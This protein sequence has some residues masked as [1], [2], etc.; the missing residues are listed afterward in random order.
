MKSFIKKRWYLILAV[1]GIVIYFIVRQ[2]ATN[3][4]TKKENKF[5]VTKQNLK[6]YLSLSGEIDADE[7]ATLRFQTSG[8]LAWVGVKEGDVVKK[9]Q[10]VASL[11]QRD[12]KNRLNKYLNTFVKNRLTFEQTHDDNWNRQYDLSESIR[13]SAQRT[14]EESQYDL[15]NSVLDVELQNL[16]L[17]YSNLWSPIDGIVTR[18]ESPFAGVNTTPTQAEIDIVNPK[19]IYF[20][21]TADQTEVINIKEKLK[22]KISMDSYSDK[23]IDAKIINIGLTPKTGETS[24]VYKVKIALDPNKIDISRFKLG[25]TGDASFL[26][27]EK[28][29]VLAVPSQFIKDNNGK[30]YVWTKKTDKRQ[31]TYIKTGGEIDDN[32]IILFG[33]EEGE[34]IYD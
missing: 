14:L 11:D 9:Y 28:N 24:T 17:E 10:S 27:K 20:L 7:K 8:R 31:K 18:V 16:S 34:T 6:E 1:I 19:T 33:L 2:N 30:K 13:K 23:E 22:G 15:N 26:V 25:M 32:T 5:T 12:I 4:A 3:L 21:A 29:N